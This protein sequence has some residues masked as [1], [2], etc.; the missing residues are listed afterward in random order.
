[1]DDTLTKSG[2]IRGTDHWL[3]QSHH[4]AF[5][6]VLLIPAG[7]NQSTMVR[8]KP[9]PRPE[10]FLTRVR[11]IFAPRIGAWFSPQRRTIH[12]IAKINWLRFARPIGIRSMLSSD[13]RG[14][15]HTRLKI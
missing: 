12:N 2:V 13:D 4:S 1:M 11:V 14:A 3:V 10:T 15:V 9:C 5:S 6:L 7:L 8:G